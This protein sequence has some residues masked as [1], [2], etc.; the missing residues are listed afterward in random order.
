MPVQI[1]SA[2]QPSM[3]VVP[4]EIS[5]NKNDIIFRSDDGRLA[6]EE[7]MAKNPSAGHG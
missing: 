7:T 2:R 6:L 3:L 1:D 4:V 5:E